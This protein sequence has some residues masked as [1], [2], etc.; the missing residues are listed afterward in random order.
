[1]S[2][3]L[4]CGDNSCMYAPKRGGMRTNGGCRCQLVIRYYGCDHAIDMHAIRRALH[5]H[6]LRIVTE[7]E[8]D[9]FRKFLRQKK[10]SK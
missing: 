3:P 9:E 6:G 8:A 2:E 7:N 10:D 1:M 5:R 4:D